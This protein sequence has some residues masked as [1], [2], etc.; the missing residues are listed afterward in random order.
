LSNLLEN[1]LVEEIKT[2]P[3][4]EFKGEVILAKSTDDVAFIPLVIKGSMRTV[5]Y[6]IYG[7]EVLIFDINEMQS[8]I[9]SITFVYCPG[10]EKGTAISNEDLVLILIPKSKIQEWTSKYKSWVEFTFL[11]N[12]QRMNEFIER[13]KQVSEKS[14]EI[15]DSINYAQRIQNAVLPAQETISNLLP[16]NFILFKPRDIVSGDYYWITKI[17]N[18]T[19][20]VVADCTGHGVPGAFMSMLGISLL[21][22]LFTDKDDIIYQWRSGKEI[23]IKLMT[24]W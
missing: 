13:N 2:L 8:R 7:Q 6:D 10:I 22:K 23:M 3:F 18:K 17:Q 4:A 19:V 15:S 21:N 20:V 5:R 16:E 14:K 24:Y 12:E 11:L 9:I 1:E